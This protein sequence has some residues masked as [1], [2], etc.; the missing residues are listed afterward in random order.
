MA[1]WDWQIVLALGC[2]A[3]AVTFLI[4]RLRRFVAGASRGCGSASCSGCPSAAPRPLVQIDRP[5]CD[6]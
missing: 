4:Q 1:N 2:V 6:R 3:G 5:H